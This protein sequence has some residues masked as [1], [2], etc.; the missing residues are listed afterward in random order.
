MFEEIHIVKGSFLVSCLPSPVCAGPHHAELVAQLGE[1]LSFGPVSAARN[2][3]EPAAKYNHSN[4][5]MQLSLILLH[6]RVL[7]ALI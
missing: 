6:L 3:P 1:T 2:L 4:G 5:E 7:P